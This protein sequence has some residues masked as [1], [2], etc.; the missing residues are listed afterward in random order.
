MKK[1][2]VILDV[3][4]FKIEKLHSVQVKGGEDCHDCGGS[5]A[6]DCTSTTKELCKETGTGTVGMDPPVN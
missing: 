4:D 1:R 2:K 3:E 6:S 5:A